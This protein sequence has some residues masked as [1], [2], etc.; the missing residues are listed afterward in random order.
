[1]LTPERQQSELFKV[2]YQ[3]RRQSMSAL[4]CFDRIDRASMPL[5]SGKVSCCG[6]RGATVRFLHLTRVQKPGCH[7]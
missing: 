7:N 6:L 2:V 4:E 1:M 5:A 3:N